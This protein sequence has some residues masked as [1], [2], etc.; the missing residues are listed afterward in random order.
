MIQAI[1]DELKNYLYTAAKPVQELLMISQDKHPLWKDNLE[2][3]QLANQQILQPSGAFPDERILAFVGLHAQTAIIGKRS[4]IGFLITNFR[5]LT[6]TDFSVIGTSK[7]AQINLFTQNQDP[8]DV[9]N[10]IWSDFFIK[11][12]LS[13]PQEQL[14]ALKEALDAVV[15]IVLPELQKMNYLPKEIEKSATIHERIKDLGLQNVLKSYAQEEKLLKKFAEKHKV[16]DIILGVVDKPFFGGVYGLVITLSGIT[17]RD[18]MEDS[19]TSTWNE[20]KQYPATISD[21]NDTISA[22]RQNHIIPDYQKEYLP[23][24]ILL[25]NELATG[26]VSII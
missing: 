23:S 3:V 24:I 18:L 21:K 7:S 26:E 17:S 25:I 14:S 4:S 8:K 5:I 20:I 11:N 9:I 13:I 22:G 1:E 16:S 19:V 10:R 2:I 15:N 6:Q 12:T